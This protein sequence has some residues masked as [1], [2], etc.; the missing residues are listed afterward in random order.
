[1]LEHKRLTGPPHTEEDRLAVD[2]HNLQVDL[3]SRSKFGKL[4][5]VNSGHLMAVEQP[6]IIAASIRYV[7]RQVGAL[8]RG[9]LQK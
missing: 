8:K 3:G 5:E 6:E 2:W 7:I 1:M 9:A 4:I